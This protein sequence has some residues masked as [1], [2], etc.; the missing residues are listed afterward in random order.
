MKC[1]SLKYC[2]TELSPSLGTLP[3]QFQFLS[4]SH[5][6]ASHLLWLR[7]DLLPV[8]I[9]SVR[10]LDTM[11]VMFGA[12][13]WLFSPGPAWDAVKLTLTVGFIC[14]FV[15]IDPIYSGATIVVAQP[16]CLSIFNLSPTQNTGLFTTD[17][18]GVGW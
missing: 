14:P 10:I 11:I 6:T 17:S 5:A 2:D 13:L 3:V 18:D 1:P 8:K 9:R 16:S 4:L 15:V 7:Y 12:L